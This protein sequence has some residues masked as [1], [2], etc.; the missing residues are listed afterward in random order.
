MTF[1]L[2]DTGSEFPRMLSRLK[3]AHSESGNVLV[4]GDVGNRYTLI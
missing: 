4:V 1:D 3:F 2:M